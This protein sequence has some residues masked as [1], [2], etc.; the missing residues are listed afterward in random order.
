[1]LSKE[2]LALSQCQLREVAVDPST[3]VTEHILLYRPPDGKHLVPD[4]Y[5]N[6]E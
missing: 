4:R 1:V 5:T 2:L 6:L 3:P